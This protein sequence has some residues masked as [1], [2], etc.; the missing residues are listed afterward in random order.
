MLWD[1]IMSKHLD[2]AVFQKGS[3]MEQ[4]KGG[5]PVAGPSREGTLK[6]QKK[7][8]NET[9]PHAVPQVDEDEI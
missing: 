3:L 4:N 9:V 2:I 8:E 1:N 7:Q 6:N 5:I